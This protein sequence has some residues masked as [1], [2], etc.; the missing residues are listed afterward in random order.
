VSGQRDRYKTVPI[1]FFSLSSSTQ[2]S[3]GLTQKPCEMTQKP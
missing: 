1:I 2:T 3:S